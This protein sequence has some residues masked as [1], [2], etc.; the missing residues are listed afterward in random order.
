MTATF[1]ILLAV[2]LAPLGVLGL[3]I[4]SSN[5]HGGRQRGT[6]MLRNAK[7]VIYKRYQ[8]AKLFT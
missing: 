7:K 6:K 1:F 3:I 5:R 8:S 2:A 4:T